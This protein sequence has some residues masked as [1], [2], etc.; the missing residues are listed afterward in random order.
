[1][2]QSRPEAQTGGA[3]AQSTPA[4]LVLVGLGQEVRS[5]R[6]LRLHSEFQASLI[7]MTPKTKQRPRQT[8][9]EAKRWDL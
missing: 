8:R 9:A 6:Q 3:R 1:M 7:Y 5:S 4:F 2:T